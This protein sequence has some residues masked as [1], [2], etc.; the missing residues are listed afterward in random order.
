MPPSD[1]DLEPREV[2]KVWAS[3]HAAAC[4]RKLRGER[5][6]AFS[7]QVVDDALDALAHGSGA[8]QAKLILGSRQ[9]LFGF[10]V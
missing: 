5:V 9:Q 1:W 7:K 3:G 8:R 4:A 10:V 6:T 2:V